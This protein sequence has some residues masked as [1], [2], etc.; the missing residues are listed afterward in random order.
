MRTLIPTVLAPVF[1]QVL[2]IFILMFMTGRA[3]VADLKAHKLRISD[4]ALGQNAWPDKTAQIG[5]AFNNQ[6]Q[7]PLLFFVLVIFTLMTGKQDYIFVACEWLFVLLRIG[8]AFIHVTSNNVI[9]RFQLYLAGAIVL[10]LMW[11]WYAIR[12]MAAI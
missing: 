11:L 6:F 4:I 8:H 12:I 7:L 5:N 1:V 10:M 9:H 3:R 2:L